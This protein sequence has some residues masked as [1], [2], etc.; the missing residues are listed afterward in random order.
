MGNHGGD[1]V[2]GWDEIE[3]DWRWVGDGHGQETG[4]HV[5]RGMGNAI[6]LVL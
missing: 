5:K 3:S 4:K 1:T 2:V 6:F